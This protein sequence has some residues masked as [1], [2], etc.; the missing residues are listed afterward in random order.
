MGHYEY[1]WYNIRDSAGNFWY[2]ILMTADALA[3]G[4][5]FTNMAK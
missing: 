3:P 2:L 1:F 5:P 4:A